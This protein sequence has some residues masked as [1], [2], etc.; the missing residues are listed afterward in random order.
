M[1]E[2]EVLGHSVKLKSQGDPEFIDEVVDLVD[3][4]LKETEEKTT[5]LGVAAHQV[6]LLACLDLAEEYLKVKKS[7]SQFQ[8]KVSEKSSKLKTLLEEDID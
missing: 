8:S 6:A 7:V 2:L 3:Q 1:V 5:H 4:R